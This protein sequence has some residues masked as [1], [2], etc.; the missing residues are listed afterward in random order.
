MKT[1]AAIAFA[2]AVLSRPMAAQEPKPVPKDAVRVSIS[3]CTKG[4]IFTVGSRPPDETSARDIP[5]G[6]HLRMNVPKKIMAQIKAHEGSMIQITGLMK[7]GQFNPTGVSLGGGV[8]ITPG[9]SPTDSGMPR[10][11]AGSQIMIDVETWSPT[12]GGCRLR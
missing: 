10:S 1:A 12:A 3:G 2:L 4:Y 9:G 8:R 5:E 7:K 11:S 6:T